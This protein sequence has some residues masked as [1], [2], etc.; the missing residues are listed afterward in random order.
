ML[1]H[2]RRGLSLSLDAQF[3]CVRRAAPVMKRQRSGSITIISSV[4]GLYGYYPLHTS[5]AA[6]KWEVIGFTKALAVELNV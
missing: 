4:A 6:A 1:D 2:W 5:Y 3:L